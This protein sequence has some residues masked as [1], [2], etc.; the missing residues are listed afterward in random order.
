ML[1]T[2]SD[3]E[4]ELWS[5]LEYYSEIEEVGLDLIQTKGLQPPSDH[6]KIFHWFQAFVRQ[7]KSY[8]SSAKTLHYRSSSLLYYYSFLNLVKAY[9]LL[10]QPQMIM[11][12]RVLHGLFYEIPTTN[13][14]FQLEI[15]RVRGGAFPMFYEAQTSTVI[16]STTNLSL[17]IVNLLSYPTEISYQYRLSGYGG[18]NTLSSL[19]VAAVDR[20]INQVWTILGFPAEASLNGFLSLHTN[21]LHTYQEVQINQDLLALVFGMSVPEL[22]YFRFFQ[23]IAT[24][25]ALDNGGSIDQVVFKQKIVNDLSPDYSSHYFDDNRDFDLVLPYTDTTNTTPIPITEVLAIYAAMF[26]LS[27]LVRYRPDYLEA[28]LRMPSRKLCKGRE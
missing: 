10:I 1:T 13:T 15:I 17:N 4:R 24:T 12:Q 22:Y 11:D 27:S 14:D 23:E 25:Q 3:T 21:F 6:Q 16:S 28:L 7:A 19:A 18:P 20:T 2:A 26:Y 5:A 9:L 8:Y